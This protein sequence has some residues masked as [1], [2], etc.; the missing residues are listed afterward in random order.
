MAS[1]SCLVPDKPLRQAVCDFEAFR[2]HT[3]PEKPRKPPVCLQSYVCGSRHGGC[4]F[5]GCHQAECVL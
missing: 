5:G 3:P 1:A 2:R 4:S